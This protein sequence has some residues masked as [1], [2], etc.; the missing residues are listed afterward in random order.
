MRFVDYANG[1]DIDDIKTQQRLQKIDQK[2]TRATVSN[3]MQKG[4]LKIASQDSRVSSVEHNVLLDTEDR[5]K[6]IQD[7]EVDW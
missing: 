7:I 6:T 2:E 5:E 1:M 4:P 3:Q